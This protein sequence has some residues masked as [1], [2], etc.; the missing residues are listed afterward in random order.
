MA[1]TYDTDTARGKV[2]L[3]IGDTDSDSYDFEDA[4]V[5][6]FLSQEGSN[7]YRSAALALR[8]LATSKVKLARRVRLSLN[9]EVDRGE[10]AKQLLELAREYEAKADQDAPTEY[11]D[12]FDD[13]LDRFGVD[14]SKYVGTT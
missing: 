1:F 2:R 10:V 5:D 3:L 4:E 12:T 7:V 11:L 13:G 14:K 9:L 6:V 8:T